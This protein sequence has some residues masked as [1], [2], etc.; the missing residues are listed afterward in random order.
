[1][2]QTCWSSVLI[3]YVHWLS[4]SPANGKLNSGLQGSVN[5]AAA[6]T[7]FQSCTRAASSSRV[8]DEVNDWAMAHVR[9]DQ[10]FRRRLALLHEHSPSL[11]FLSLEGSVAGGEGMLRV[12]RVFLASAF[13][14]SLVGRLP[15][16]IGAPGGASH[17]SIE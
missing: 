11:I 13:S 9:L 7:H 15:V 17:N 3:I 2:K 12:G 8:A 14:A 5:T 4:P 10:V 16:I 1:M 6:R